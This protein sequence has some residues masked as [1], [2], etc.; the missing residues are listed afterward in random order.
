MYYTKI[1]KGVLRIF[2]NTKP[3]NG[4]KFKHKKNKTGAFSLLE[5]LVVI[6]IV[7][8]LSMIAITGWS[9][10]SE[11][12]H[13]AAVESETSKVVSFFSACEAKGV[14]HGLN[15]QSTGQQILE[16]ATEGK[17]KINP[18]LYEDVAKRLYVSPGT[19]MVTKK[20][21]E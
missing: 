9:S 3:K 16:A 15:Q 12:A 1:L 19:N 11:A 13:S 10:L 5:M 20:I 2:Q 14:K 6:G 18:T 21:V 4:M 8:F 17:V 7:G